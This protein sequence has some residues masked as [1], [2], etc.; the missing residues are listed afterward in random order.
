[1]ATARPRGLII[2]AAPLKGRAWCLMVQVWDVLDA[3]CMPA[4]APIRQPSA[5]LRIVA[6]A[7]GASP[8]SPTAGAYS[9][10]RQSV[11]TS[12][13]P[14]VAP[15]ARASSSGSRPSAGSYGA[16]AAGATGAPPTTSSSIAW[17]SGSKW[18]P[19]ARPGSQA[20]GGSSSGARASSGK[21]AGGAERQ[22]SRPAS[23]SAARPASGGTCDA[24]GGPLP[25]ASLAGVDPDVQQHLEAARAQLDSRDWKERVAGVDGLQAA[26][27]LPPEGQLW[28]A[29]ALAEPVLD[30]NLK[31]Q[32]QVRVGAWS[33][34]TQRGVFPCALASVAQ[35]A[36]PRP[37]PCRLWQPSTVCWQ[38]LGRAWRRQPPRWCPRFA[39]AATAATRQCARW[40]A[41]CG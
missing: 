31:V 13:G 21:T 17:V 5:A 36:L 32:Q 29:C 28:V 6:A 30:A 19:S 2:W 37:W 25:V 34:L 24:V 35:Q 1:M 40:G 39:S 33:G 26:P 41:C 16:P 15:A 12:A 9:P 20:G 22:G 27:Q 3:E 4:P 18:Q 38:P 7:A 23:G 14:Q 8:A 11:P 10:A